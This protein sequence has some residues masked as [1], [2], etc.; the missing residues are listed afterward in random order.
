MIT[1]K[2]NKNEYNKFLAEG[3]YIVNFSDFTLNL[4]F[5]PSSV[6]K[7]IVFSP[8]F[9]D[10]RSHTHPYFQRISWFHEIDCCCI[11]LTDPTLD[12]S[13][14]VSIG[15]FIGKGK[16]H[17]LRE[18]A[19][20]IDGLASHYGITANNTMFFGSSAGGF[21]SLGMASVMRGSLA[22]A[23]NPQTDVFNFHHA[24]ELHKTFTHCFSGSDMLSI[25]SAFAERCVLLDL[26]RL[27][28]CVPRIRYWQNSAD[29]YHYERHMI[30]FVSGLSEFSL[31]YQLSLIVEN[32]KELG[33]NPPGLASF[34]K[35]FDD[36]VQS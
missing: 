31:D 26:Y 13:E 6:K 27:E 15:W 19:I 11:S 30:P 5:K 25:R 16:V 12:L 34:K 1:V 3:H 24:G 33:H 28:G 9:L 32:I 18:I 7:L 20:F 4:Y 17:Y 14:Q 35:H 2:V 10:R 22:F 29:K 8:G 21:A 36:F 23:V